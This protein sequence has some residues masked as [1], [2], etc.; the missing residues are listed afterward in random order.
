MRRRTP[1]LDAE[2]GSVLLLGIGLL[3]VCLLAVVVVV[4][5]AAAYLQRRALMAVADAAALAG[6]Q[7][8][9]VEA[10][11][12]SGATTG[13]RL[14]PQAVDAAARRQVARARQ[15]GSV[16]IDG[17]A[18]DGETVRIRLSQPVDLPFLGDALAARV[19]VESAARLDYRPEP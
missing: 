13:T 6:A 5:G 19:R 15:V 16:T 18:T 2:D 9:D 3:A 10:Y 12:R 11:Y 14:A 1:G 4:D 17:L 8:I 7:A